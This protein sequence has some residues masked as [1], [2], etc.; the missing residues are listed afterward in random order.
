VDLDYEALLQIFL[1]ETE[2]GLARLEQGLVTLESHPGDREALDEVFRVIHTL[3]GDAGML[4][5]SAVSEVAH[6]LEGL[7][8]RARAGELT[9]DGGIITLLLHAVDVLRGLLAS[10]EE[11]HEE[12]GPDQ[13]VLLEL[14]AAAARRGDEAARKGATAEPRSASGGSGDDSRGDDAGVP[15]AS[16]GL[17]ADQQARSLRVPVDKLDKLLDLT[18]ELGVA[19]GQLALA[20][21]T[22][23]AGVAHEHATT[24]S[25][26]RGSLKTHPARR[27]SAPRSGGAPGPDSRGYRALLEMHRET[28]RLHRELQELV[29]NLRMVPVGPAFRR[30]VRTVRDL[31]RASGKQAQLTLT[32]A[33]VEADTSMVEGLRDPL[34]HMIRNALD[35]G[36]E[37]PE[38]RLRQG[39]DPVGEVRISAGYRDGGIRIEVAD[40]GAGLD[41]NRIFE[42]A[43]SLGLAVDSSSPGPR[44][45]SMIFQAGLSTVDDVTELSGRGVGM[46]VVR[47]NVEALRGSITVTSEP[48]R[49]TTFAIQLPLTLAV[50]DGFRVGLGDET[51]VLPLDAIVE[52]LE[53][54]R[55]RRASAAAGAAPARA[56]ARGS[57]V[58]D[59]RGQTVPYLRLRELLAVPSAPPE[60]ENVVVVRHDSGPVGLVVDAIHGQ[61][62][63]II[64]PLGPLVRTQPGITGSTL[65]EDGRVALILDVAALL[66]R[67]VC[68][69]PTEA[70]AS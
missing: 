65:L 31:A 32:G 47:R 11:G 44:W 17:L 39:K 13:P 59:L 30:H 70:V 49:G 28:D 4:G 1:T 23:L 27:I 38:V 12:A 45:D 14:L 50:I 54:P 60:R 64:K 5:F 68:S 7:L 15:P 58:L 25:L 55:S 34:T 2:E 22:A 19:R 67:N 9:I 10:S 6:A 56:S 18:G 36:I 51:Y 40:D 42:R 8:D 24:R 53:L 66:N 69:L 52:S 37:R 29:M 16:A 61:S 57:G 3:K 43:R 62:Q 35:H 33:D 48:G 20:L 41:R 26:R 21:S 63:T 46:D